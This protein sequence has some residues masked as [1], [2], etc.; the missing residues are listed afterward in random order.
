MGA[1]FLVSIFED[2]DLAVTVRGFRGR[3][4]ATEPRAK[5]SL[6]DLDLRGPVAWL[7]GNEG[8]GL[9]ENALGAAT[10]RVRIPLPGAAESLNVAAAVAICLFE[11]VR[12]KAGT[13][14]LAPGPR[15]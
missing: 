1:H 13:G 10:D 6:Y 15:L 3:I 8:A 14:G 4:V 12:Q 2:V 5:V 9:S 7:F 11:Q